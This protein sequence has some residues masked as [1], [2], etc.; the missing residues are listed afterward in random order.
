MKNIAVTGSSGFVGKYL[1]ESLSKKYTIIKI[2]NRKKIQYL[3]NIKKFNI[4]IHLA[5]KKKINNKN[6]NLHNIL[7]TKKLLDY[8]IKYKSSMIF[9]STFN[10]DPYTSNFF[11]NSKYI[12]SKKHCEDLCKLYANKYGLNIIILRTFNIYDNNLT[13]QNLFKKII[14]NHKN[15]KI[16]YLYKNFSRDYL[17]I[18][19]FISCIQKIIHKKINEFKIFELGSGKTYSNLKIL[20]LFKKNGIDLK[21]LNLIENKSFPVTTKANIIKIQSFLNWSPKINLED[22]IKIFI[23]NL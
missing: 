5:F 21:K 19:D 23:K 12:L 17:H 3:K 22:S 10:T 7:I 15:K 20:N 13:Q 9:I 1:C 18:D 16:T 8:C 11:Y 2:G 4:L 6:D 14:N